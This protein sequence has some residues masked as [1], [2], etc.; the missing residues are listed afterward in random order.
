MVCV[1]VCV[2]V[3]CTVRRYVSHD[4]TGMV[5]HATDTD[6]ANSQLFFL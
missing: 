5:L 4:V 3:P 1:C 2:P 6:T